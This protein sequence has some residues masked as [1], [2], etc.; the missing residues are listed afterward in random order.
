MD[1][2]KPLPDCIHDE[3]RW[4]RVGTEL[5]ETL[6]PKRE[7][8]SVREAEGVGIEQG[9]ATFTFSAVWMQMSWLCRT[10]MYSTHVLFVSSSDRAAPGDRS[11][12]QDF[13]SPAFAHKS[14]YSNPKSGMKMVE[15]GL[16][17]HTSSN[18]GR[19]DKNQ[20]PNSNSRTGVSNKTD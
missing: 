10:I 17:V 3:L 9:P 5:W 19:K 15:K 18:K 1:C 13:L 20:N 6:P 11:R 14:I 12:K 2:G 16:H 8:K 4:Q 7:R